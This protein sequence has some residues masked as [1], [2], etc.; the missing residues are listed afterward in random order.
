M[1]KGLND[2]ESKYIKY[3]PNL[4]FV[5]KILSKINPDDIYVLPPALEAITDI[6]PSSI[7]QE[8]NDLIQDIAVLGE[9]MAKCLQDDVAVGIPFKVYQAAKT[10]AE[11]DYEVISLYENHHATNLKGSIQAETYPIL[12]EMGTELTQYK[13]FFN[14]QFYDG[15]AD[16]EHLDV[17]ADKEKAEIEKIVGDDINGKLS[18]TVYNKME[19]NAQL[20][21]YALNRVENAKKYVKDLNEVLCY[22]TNQYYNGYVRD[23]VTT[24]GNAP[25]E[26]LK[27]FNSMNEIKFKQSVEMSEQDSIRAARLNTKELKQGMNEVVQTIANMKTNG[28]DNLLT[29]IKTLD[30]NFDQSPVTMIMTDALDRIEFVQEAYDEALL[31]LFKHNR[32]DQMLKD[33][34][35]GTMLE[36]KKSRQLHTLISEIVLE[37]EN[38]TF[39]VDKFLAE[40]K[41]ELPGT[42]CTK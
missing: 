39:D 13:D 8:L 1:G 9:R 4:G 27:D 15:K 19:V 16:Y 42:L 28:S 21:R 6:L 34:Q 32:L 37:K 36:K 26:T 30:S 14:K 22:T 29:W 24:L 7:L 33:D 38:G 12:L 20:S 10:S 11:P 31:E 3:K 5:P 2:K 18:P 23:V 17:N 40:K 41:L 35:I 25:T